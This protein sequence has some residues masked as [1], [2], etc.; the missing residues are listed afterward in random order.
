MTEET[1]AQIIYVALPKGVM[2]RIVSYMANRPYREVA[3]LLDA[4]TQYGIPQKDNQD[5]HYERLV[6]Q[7][8]DSSGTVADES[9][10]NGG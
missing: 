10:N 5:G 2:E 6:G 4:V 9:G 1:S 3:H 8:D 7:R